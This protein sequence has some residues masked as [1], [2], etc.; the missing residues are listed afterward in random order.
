M[1]V[2]G[3]ATLAGLEKLSPGP[4]QTVFETSSE[5]RTLRLT[6]IDKRDLPD[7]GTIETLWL[8]GDTPSSELRCSVP[9]HCGMHCL[10]CIG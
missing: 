3:L 9:Q 7:A 6:V 2:F 4:A 1:G 5:G 8:F 10:G